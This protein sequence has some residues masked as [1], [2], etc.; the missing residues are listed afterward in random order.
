ML[1]CS[2]LAEA[3][4]AQTSFDHDVVMTGLE[5][6]PG[7]SGAD[8]LGDVDQRAPWV[9]ITVDD[10]SCWNV[11]LGGNITNL[12]TISFNLNTPESSSVS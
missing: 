2:T 10:E 9:H 7:S 5:L 8:L 4:A 1:A 12:G 6:G 11:N 3:L